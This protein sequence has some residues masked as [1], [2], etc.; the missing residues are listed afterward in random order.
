[1]WGVE[2]YSYRGEELDE[3][4]MRNL[5]LIVDDDPAIRELYG[6]AL[7]EAGL[8]VIC[9]SDGNEALDDVHL[10]QP[11]LVVLD[12]LMSRVSGQEVLR[13]LQRD[14][15]IGHL[16]LLMLTAEG[17]TEV[18]PFDWPRGEKA[19]MVKPADPKD[20]ADRVKGILCR[21]IPS[22]HLCC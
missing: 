17:N 6:E 4:P 15:G 19:W 7:T 12:L 5:I 13:R 10:L 20:L 9:A 3:R 14:E 1:M 21:P 8:D 11:D 18:D 16:D 22:F 2:R